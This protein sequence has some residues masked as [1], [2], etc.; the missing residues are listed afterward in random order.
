MRKEIK[1]GDDGNLTVKEKLLKA[2]AQ[3]ASLTTKLNT[4]IA[5]N[6]ANI[7]SKK[8]IVQLYKNEIDTIVAPYEQ[9]YERNAMVGEDLRS[10]A[11][12]NYE[13]ILRKNIEI[14][15]LNR[16]IQKAKE[17]LCRTKRNG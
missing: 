11:W 6:N 7:E 3:I 1:D 4:A 5:E 15:R 12:E 13:T 8:K 16:I 14:A 2:E 17:E 9:V 10:R